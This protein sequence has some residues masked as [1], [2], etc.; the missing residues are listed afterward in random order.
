MNLRG[1]GGLTNGAASDRVHVRQFSTRER[2]LI[3][4]DGIL[5]SLYVLS[6]G[7]ESSW[8]LSNY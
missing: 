6:D 1:K 7:L 5:E 4:A 8:N 3:T 2:M